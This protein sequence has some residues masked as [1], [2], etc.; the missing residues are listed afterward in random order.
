MFA[1]SRKNLLLLELPGELSIFDKLK[2]LFFHYQILLKMMLI[3]CL[4]KTVIEYFRG[5]RY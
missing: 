1:E 4:N 5:R 3:H 2:N